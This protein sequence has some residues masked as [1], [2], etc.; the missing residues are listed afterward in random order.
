MKLKIGSK[1]MLIGAAI[2]V[3]PFTIMGIIVSVQAKRGITAL[4]EGQLT[5]IT[6]SMADYVEQTLSGY[7]NATMALAASPDVVACAEASDR[8]D[9]KVVQLSAALSARL[10]TLN[11]SKQ[12]SNAVLTINTVNIK[13]R[14]VAGSSPASLNLDLSDREFII[15]AL[16]GEVFISQMLISRSTGTATV[17]FAAPVIGS[18]G[19]PIGVCS[20]TMK[21]SVITDELARY[22]MGKTGY[23]AMIDRDGLIVLH[24]N[25]DFI[26]KKNIKNDPGME[27][28]AKHALS[29]ESGVQAY[30]YNGVGK[31]CS[32][33]TVPSIGWV[34][35]GLIPTDEFLATAT[36]II[37]LVII[38]ALIAVFFA[39]ILLYFLSRSI[40]MPVKAA[41]DHAM[42][43]ANGNLDFVI[44]SAFLSRGDE[45]GDLALAFKKQREN[46][47]QV[48]KE[49]TTAATNVAQGSEVMSS[50]A[51]S[52]SQGASEQAASA[53][54]VSS[55][56]EEMDA[57][58][59]QNA[60]NAQATKGIADKAVKDIEEGSK[61][62]TDSVTAMGQIADKI[63]IIEE[64]ARQTNLLALN[65]AIE[66]ARAGESG[67]GFAVVAS[68]VRKLAER[69]QK[70]AAEITGLS[71]STVDLSQRAN[72]IIETI[73]PDIRKT[74]DLVQEITA[75]SQEQSSGVDQIGKAMIQ[76]DSVIQKSASESE[77]MAAM[78]EELSGQAQQFIATIGFFTLPKEAAEAIALTTTKVTPKAVK[79]TME[80]P[81]SPSARLP[82]SPMRP[83]NGPRVRQT[84]KPTAIVPVDKATSRMEA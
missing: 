14:V 49:I 46:L 15:K 52:M 74:A 79:V 9:S 58:I 24:K 84:A 6:E 7:V 65:A 34:V 39:L 35:I 4:E 73:V 78:S 68:E 70:A 28:V 63:S 75:A 10:A 61:A 31:I 11:Q 1:L 67:K 76:L 51:Q 66:A 37:N 18:S 40:S 77:E 25:K 62:V 44:S 50:T 80:R 36:D 53:E 21:T 16:N 22:K 5:T 19:K 23:F 12:Y 27:I 13:G 38:I 71:R 2:V 64:I 3:I 82:A 33:S 30:L 32:F 8:G 43:M 26:L 59:K 54:E 45:I 42:S 69:S 72:R 83:Q 81:T 20:M 55:S 41:A 56:V 60:D 57:T 17:A 29:G 47:I 48:V